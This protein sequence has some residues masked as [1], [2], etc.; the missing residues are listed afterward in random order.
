MHREDIVE[1]LRTE[2]TDE[3]QMVR[4]FLWNGKEYQVVNAECFPD[5]GKI[6]MRAIFQQAINDYIKLS[7]K[8]LLK[9]EDKVNFDTA[10]G[11][12]FDDDYTIDFGG[13]DI[14]L[15]DMVFFM[16]GSDPNMEMLRAGIERMQNSDDSPEVQSAPDVESSDDD[17]D[18][19]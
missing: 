15:K 2:Q 18:D 9:E 8:K 16:T 10:K 7:S 11:F 17:G 12:L 6:L 19:F 13:M 14:T 3:G 5:D 1:L 4:Y